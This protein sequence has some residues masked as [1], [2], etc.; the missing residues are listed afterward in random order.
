MINLRGASSEDEWYRDEI[1]ICKTTGIEHYD[2][3]MCA[4]K[5]PEP[6]TVAL[7]IRTL[8]IAPRPFLVHC[9]SG[10]D[11]T[12]L[13]SAV[14][15]MLSSSQNP[16]KAA[17][18]GLTLWHGHIP[19]GQTSAM[20]RFFRLYIESGQGMDFEQWVRNAYP[21]IFRAESNLRDREKNNKTKKEVE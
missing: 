16:S 10:S 13:A 9:K 11:R 19:I 8:R 6:E 3:P 4:T 14:W 12:G 21:A 7:L 1:A 18:H 2:I 5:L 17:S 20:D 15:L